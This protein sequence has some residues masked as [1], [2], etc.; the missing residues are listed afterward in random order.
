MAPLPISSRP[1]IRKKDE[2]IGFVTRYFVRHTSVRNYIVEINKEQYDVYKNAPGYITIELPWAINGYSNTVYGANNVKF[3]GAKQ[4]NLKVIELYEAKMPGLKRILLDPLEYFRGKVTS[5]V[6][7]SAALISSTAYSNQEGGTIQTTTSP[8]L[9]RTTLG[10]LAAYSSTP[11]SDVSTE[12]VASDWTNVGTDTTAPT[13]NS[14]RIRFNTTVSAN[15]RHMVLNTVAP[16]AD[17]MMQFVYH[18][19]SSTN[20]RATGVARNTTNDFT[21][22]ILTRVPS[23]GS[24]GTNREL[25]L[26][27]I[28]AA[29]SVQLVS[30]G[31]AFTAPP[32]RHTV[33]VI[34]TD[35]AAFWF[36]QGVGT[37]FASPLTLAGAGNWGM[38]MAVDFGSVGTTKTM[39]FSEFYLMSG[40]YVTVTNLPSGYSA[41][42]LDAGNVSLSSAT[43]VSGTAL[44][45][46]LEVTF[47]LAVKIAIY[48]GGN[49]L[50]YSATPAETIWGGDVWDWS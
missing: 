37:T 40:R 23:L 8:S 17:A 14:G 12:F 4:K 49:N 7:T 6:S 11:V 15:T 29:A 28:I 13:L 25:R 27:E 16:R 36:V 24:T 5:E 34:G 30:A 39:D 35:A 26:R 50:V 10:R 45:E 31:T 43:E 22:Q 9:T 33:A 2:D 19:A 18:S 44:I 20:V 48:D 46:L 41:A 1:I 38:G 32:S 21:N 47:P 42:V 3:I